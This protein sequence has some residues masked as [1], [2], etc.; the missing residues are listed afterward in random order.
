MT[1]HAVRI[2]TTAG[3]RTRPSAPEALRG[4]KTL[5]LYVSPAYAVTT[6]ILNLIKGL[7][8]FCRFRLSPPPLT[9]HGGHA[10]HK[11]GRVLQS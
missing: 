9:G 2:G 3:D 8:T 1:R 5:L 11:Q 7:A 6:I 10:H 4:V